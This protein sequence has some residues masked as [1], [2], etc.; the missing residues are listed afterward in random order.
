MRV[1]PETP[2]SVAKQQILPGRVRPGLGVLTAFSAF[3]VT[4]LGILYAGTSI[5]TAFDIRVHI[6]LTTFDSPWRQLAL[7]VD[8]TAEPVGAVLIFGTLA[9][10]WLKIGHYRAV[11]LTIAGPGVTV[12]VTTLLKPLVD[13]TINGGYHS[14]PSG[15]TATTTCL[16][17]V[18]MLVVVQRHE[19]GATMGMSL[20]LVVT[21][22]AAAAMAWAQVLLNAHYPTDTIG[23]FC[24]ALVVVP[25]T[26][27]VI[28][29]IADRRRGS[30]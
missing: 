9:L 29:T 26:A 20:I 13:R 23:G 3:T 17:L 21:I 30:S 24:T 15:H 6:A 18:V 11:A 27:L 4:V 16:A 1:I 5:G 22:P 28:D 7:V 14:F 10:V 8:W 19:T 12:A 2:G 25:V